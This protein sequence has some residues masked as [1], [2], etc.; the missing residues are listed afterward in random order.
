M[1]VPAKPG[2]L[3]FI[4]PDG[5]SIRIKIYGDERFHYCVTE[6]NYPLI[7][8]DNA[9]YFTE[10][11]EGEIIPSKFIA[12]EPALRSEDCRNFLN[13]SNSAPIIEIFR[14]QYSR[15]AIV[16][17]Y[18]KNS[19]PGLFSNASF[20]TKGEVKSLVL[21]VEFPDI[22]FDERYEP[23]DYFSRMLNEP[24][25]SDQGATGSA[26]DYFKENS[27]GQFTPVF[28]VIGPIS[29]SRPEAFY[30]INGKDVIDRNAGLMIIDACKIID[31]KVDFSQYDYDNDGTI[32]NI[33][34]FY[35]GKGEASGGG[36][37]TIWPH[38]SDVKYF[39]DEK[40]VLDGKILGRYACSNEIIDDRPDGIGTFVHEFSHV[41]GLP[42][43]YA[44]SYT[45]AF[46][47]GSWDIM[48]YG[49]YNNDSRTPPLMSSFERHALGWKLPSA[50]KEGTIE[51]PSLQNKGIGL[52]ININ[53]N[54]RYYLETRIK[55]GLDTYI[56]GEGMLIWHIN[57]DPAIWGMNTV[58]DN[59][60]KQYVDIIE[61][62]NKRDERSR[63]GDIFPGIN[64]IR[65]INSSS[66]P[67]LLTWAERDEPFTISNISFNEKILL[68]R[69][70]SPGNV[71]KL[72]AP[73]LDCPPE[74]TSESF[75]VRWNEVEGAE[76]YDI[77]VKEYL[78]NQ[79]DTETLD[80]NTGLSGIPEGWDIKLGFPSTDILNPEDDS[81][82]LMFFKNGGTITS[83]ETL[84]EI[85][86]VKFYFQAV[87][88][89]E[90]SPYFEL[91]VLRD[92]EW[93]LV[94]CVYLI[95][96]EPFACLTY[97]FNGEPIKQFR[98]R[99]QGEQGVKVYFDNLTVEY[100]KD[101]LERSIVGFPIKGYRRT[102]INVTDLEPSVSY[103]FNI[104]AVNGE[105]K[106]ETVSLYMETL[107]SSFLDEP[108]DSLI[109]S[110]YIEG[111]YLIIDSYVDT[112]AYLYGI[113]GSHTDRISIRS[114]IN[115]VPISISGVI[116]VNINNR[117]YK[118]MTQL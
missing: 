85:N 92:A 31:G 4:Q 25:F 103:L 57:Y 23:F 72:E 104:T 35:A 112:Y 44:T 64:N 91:Y 105:Y 20:P 66:H 29:L 43:L 86:N 96:N 76:G 46:T 71:N 11:S 28:D 108:R 6:D 52:E 115:Y 19:N 26:K 113:D 111:G 118:L 9:L 32:D 93:E 59:P 45:D 14:E 81:P 70:N 68:A 109:G 8:K 15:R 21:L 3:K 50:P 69:F 94:D 99:I 65:S 60:E 89:Q 95:V 77:D 55:Q 51:I 22:K 41:Q 18:R 48:D 84:S 74:V 37:M 88:R 33:F 100:T 90:R 7:E 39:T 117:M 116:M 83:P 36:P 63:D 42:D 110:I 17:K 58:N 67:D 34:V 98:L 75:K 82:M 114:G 54:E 97:E 24:G 12:T 79:S 47:P 78:R 107:D 106:S 13:N 101:I 30:G 38:S 10:V 49:S 62:D 5:S 102:E 16:S 27:A 40:I 87:G 73:I 53:D 1:A 80:F 2:L 61:A 56:P